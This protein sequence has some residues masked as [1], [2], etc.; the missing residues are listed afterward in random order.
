MRQ[1]QLHIALVSCSRKHVY[2]IGPALLALSVAAPGSRVLLYADAPGREVAG[3]CLEHFR[4]SMDLR[5]L[6]IDALGGQL[7]DYSPTSGVQP[8]K[9][10]SKFAC[11]SAKLMLQGAPALRDSRFVLAL[12]IDSVANEVCECRT[13]HDARPISTLH[14]VF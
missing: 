7:P 8:K 10:V 11:A 6:P 4:T 14:S 13:A 2:E 5:V 1:D 3:D 12:D 9:Q